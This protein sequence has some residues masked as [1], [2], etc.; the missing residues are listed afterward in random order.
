MN[1]TRTPGQQ[2]LSPQPPQIR[3]LGGGTLHPGVPSV[4]PRPAIIQ[5]V[6]PKPIEDDPIELFEEAPIEQNPS[7]PGPK[8][9]VAFGV[10]AAHADR[11]YKRKPY[12]DGK[13]ACRVRSF[14]AKYSEQGIEHLDDMIN[15]WLE[16]HP[17]YE[18]KFTTTTV[19]TFEGKIREPALVVNVWF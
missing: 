7:A 17:E 10:Q 2:G 1:E 19:H 8:K 6:K 18:V 16:L 9:I 13:G 15:D 4:P 12:A 5:P 3:P 11:V 14:H